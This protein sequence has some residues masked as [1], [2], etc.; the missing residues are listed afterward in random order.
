MTRRRAILISIAALLGAALALGLYDREIDA[1]TA[2]GI[3]ERM[4]RDYHARTGHPKTEFAPREGRLWADGWEYRW[5]FKPC[6][7]VASLRVWISRNGRRV[8]YAE[9]PECAPTDG[10]PL[11][12]RIA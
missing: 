9:L 5:R 6:P 11:R 1:E 4:A 10:Q 12:P 3:A 2:A 7:D 8:R